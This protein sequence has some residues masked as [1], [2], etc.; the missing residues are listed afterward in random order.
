MTLEKHLEEYKNS[1]KINPNEQKIK[2]AIKTSMDAFYASEQK[3]M[4]SYHDFLWTP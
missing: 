1:K 2:A 3:Q 4:L